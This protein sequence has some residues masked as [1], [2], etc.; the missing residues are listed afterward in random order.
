MGL[1]NLVFLDATV[2]EPRR[3]FFRLRSPSTAILAS[4][5]KDK[6][7]LDFRLRPTAATGDGGPLLQ[8]DDLRLGEGGPVNKYKNYE[9]PV[10]LG[11]KWI[12]ASGKISGCKKL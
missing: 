8:V 10:N 6:S 5:S 7:S 9:K 11:Q 1:L 3:L 2:P 4:S 12:L